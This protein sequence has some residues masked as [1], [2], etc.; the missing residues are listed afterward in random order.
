MDDV[1]SC[2]EC[3]QQK[4]HVVWRRLGEIVN[5]QS[6]VSLVISLTHDNQL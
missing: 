6:I 3:N 4:M 2:D 1:R 5:K